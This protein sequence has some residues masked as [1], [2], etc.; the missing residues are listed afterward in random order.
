VTLIVSQRVCLSSNLMLNI[1]EIK[2]F[3]GLCPTGSL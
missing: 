2:P 3:R 1:S